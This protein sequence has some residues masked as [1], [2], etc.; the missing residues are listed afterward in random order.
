MGTYFTEKEEL[1]KAIKSYALE[2]GRN[3]KFVKNDKR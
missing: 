1:L 2:N 3:L